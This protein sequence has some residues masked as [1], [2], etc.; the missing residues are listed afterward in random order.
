MICTKW[1][2]LVNEYAV[3]VDQAVVQKLHR[4]LDELEVLFIPPRRKVHES[5]QL[6]LVE[7]HVI[8]AKEDV[9]TVRAGHR[10]IAC[11]E[12]KVALLLVEVDQRFLGHLRFEA[13]AAAR[14]SNRGTRLLVVA[15]GTGER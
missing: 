9:E 3:L 7:R 10:P 15:V 5:V 8:E 1:L 13:G 2:V 4:L 14:R 12:T 11:A 6:L